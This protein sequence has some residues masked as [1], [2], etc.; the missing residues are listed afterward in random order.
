MDVYKSRFQSFGL[1]T[2]VVDGHDVSELVKAF[3]EAA[4][5]SGQPTAI[6]AKTYKGKGFPGIED[7]DNWHGKALGADGEE[8]IKVSIRFRNLKLNSIHFTMF[9]R[10]CNSCFHD[11]LT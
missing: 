3:D 7:L 6:V 4:S 9:L 1:H 8:I 11:P 5:V 2:L 10:H